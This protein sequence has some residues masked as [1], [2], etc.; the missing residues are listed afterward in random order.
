MNMVS[1]AGGT[2]DIKTTALQST[3]SFKLDIPWVKGLWLDGSASYDA[4]YVFTKDFQTPDYVYYKDEKTGELY[5]GRSGMGSDK[6]NLSEK[7]ENPTNLYM[8]A[9]LNYD[10]TFGVHHVGAMVGYEQSETKRKL[11][12]GL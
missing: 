7:Y 1:D 10:H 2:R 5:K 6:A 9:K 4:G 3:V 12:S 11:S 8:T